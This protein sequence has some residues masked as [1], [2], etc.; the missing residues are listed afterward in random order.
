MQFLDDNGEPLSGGKLKFTETGS[1]TTL[2]TTYSDLAETT[3]NTNPYILDSSGRVSTDIFGS[4][5][6]RVTSF[7][8]D[9]VQIQ[10]FDPV[11]G[12]GAGQLDDWNAL[13]TY[14]INDLVEGSDG[15]Y[16]RSITNSNIGNDPVGDATNWN[17]VEFL[18]Y[19]NSN[20][21][22]S[23]NDIVRDTDGYLYI[24]LED[25]NTGNTPSASGD[26]WRRDNVPYRLNKTGNYTV[27]ANELLSRQLT[28]TNTSASGSI[29]ITLDAALKGGRVCFLCAEDQYL[30][31]TLDGTDTVSYGTVTGDPGGYVRTNQAGTYW[32]MECFADGE[33]TITELTN[34]LHYD[35]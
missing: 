3:P 15:N 33:W 4:G 29:E 31:G 1:S 8:S 23:E 9:D 35:Q 7:D 27:S 21:E 6:Y 32:C 13:T 10:Q 28:I 24:S 34:Q 16:Y 25:S 20:Y 30:R 22:Y 5:S 19:Y 26:Y 14:Q 17:Q 11:G 18:E 2:K 12:E